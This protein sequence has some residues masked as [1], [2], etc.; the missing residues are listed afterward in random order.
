MQSIPVL[1]VDLTSDVTN[2]KS[3]VIN[4]MAKASQVYLTNV[5]SFFDDVMAHEQEMETDM[6]P[7]IAL[8]HAKST[9]VNSPFIVVGKYIDGIVWNNDNKVKLVILIGA[10]EHANKEHLSIIAKLASNLADDDF[11]QDLLNSDIQFVANKI[12]GLY[13]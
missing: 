3:S 10:P 4:L 2:Q 5:K 8:P 11:I 1:S 7:D 9:A 13:E 6:L 12:R